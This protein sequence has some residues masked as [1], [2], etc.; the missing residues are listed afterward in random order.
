MSEAKESR[1]TSTRKSA[2][3]AAAAAAAA[4]G[5]S[6]SAGSSDAG[7]NNS[8]SQWLPF[9]F[10]NLGAYGIQQDELDMENLD[11]IQCLDDGT[12]DDDYADETDDERESSAR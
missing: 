11:A 10:E 8:A 9:T 6:G 2:A 1:R 5:G 7:S 3:A 4:N 12:D